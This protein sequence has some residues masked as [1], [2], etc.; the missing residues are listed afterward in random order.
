M[1][2]D[3]VVAARRSRSKSQGRLSIRHQGTA[4]RIKRRPQVRETRALAASAQAATVSSGAT[5]GGD[6]S[7]KRLQTWCMTC[8]RRLCWFY[9]GLAGCDTVP[10]RQ[11]Q[12]A[13]GNGI[14]G[15]LRRLSKG[16]LVL[17]RQT[18]PVWCGHV[19]TTISLGR[20][21]SPSARTVPSTP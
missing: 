1:H 8:T 12:L 2:A 3:P 17:R 15:R 9:R 16:P 6:G 19:R 7:G 21:T 4:A 5:G 20:M 11:D 10:A 18:Y 13:V 14:R